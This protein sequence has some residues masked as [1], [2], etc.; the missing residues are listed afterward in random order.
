MWYDNLNEKRLWENFNNISAI[1]RESGNEEEIRKFLLSWA[2]DH[3]LKAKADKAGN[4]IIYK[5][6]TEGKENVPSLCL[7]G[8]M[9]MVCVKTLESKHN[10]KTDPIE[11]VLDGD[12][13]RAKDTSL[14]GDN[15]IAVAVALT[16]LEDE[17][18]SHGP[19]EALFTVS[20]ET[21]LTGAYNIEPK[22]ISS[23]LL[24][25]LDSEEEG[26]IYNGC[27]G[28]I[29][30]VARRHAKRKA[31]DEDSEAFTLTVS[32]L[33]GG[34]SGGE[35][36]KDR[37]NAIKL[38]ARVLK[39]IPSL[40]ISTL[41]GGSRRNV[42]PS[43]CTV[44]FVVKKSLAELVVATVRKVE[45]EVKEEYKLHDP[46]ISFSLEKLEELP[47]LAVK[48]KASRAFIEALYLAP[49]GVRAMS[50]ATPGIVETSNNVAVVKLEGEFFCCE[51]ST[52]SLVESAKEELSRVVAATFEDFGAEITI[53]GNYPSWAP[54]PNSKFTQKVAD[55]Y[56]KFTKKAPVVTSIHAGLECGIINS[57]IPK[58]DSLS[59]GPD[60]H[61]VH[62]V[63]E[64]LSASSAERTLEFL[65]YLISHL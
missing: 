8:H 30:I 62:S 13:V 40:R 24:L 38:V 54:D 61:D 59:I 45:A 35:I 60:L 22:L 64:H 36:H 12:T 52:R 42:I 9:D 21:G 50:Q 6:A 5:D 25:N 11:I 34:H 55:M 31:V 47:A 53:S 56:K 14:G 41:E 17:E 49:H 44:S 32:G 15:G 58:M 65:R 7:Q 23:R 1:P 26:I 18:L 4:V 33:L 16:L 19:L 46:N 39:K 27:A 10:F 2:K 20:E 48:E 37:A 51:C 63:N 3:K 29:D 43:S 57:M 28:G